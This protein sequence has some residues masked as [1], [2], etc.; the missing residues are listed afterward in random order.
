MAKTTRPTAGGSHYVRGLDGVFRRIGPPVSRRTRK[1]FAD[2]VDRALEDQ[3]FSASAV[4]DRIREALGC[5]SDTELAWIFGTS[6]QHI[7]NRRNRNTVPY[8]EALFVA[9]W[10]DVSLDYILTGRGRMKTEHESS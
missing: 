6:P 3:R 4:I 7:W 8:R 1:S 9:L 10:A 2:A 5:D